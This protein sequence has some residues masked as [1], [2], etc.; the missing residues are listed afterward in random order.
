MARV[1]RWRSYLPALITNKS[2]SLFGPIVPR[3]AE[4]NRMIFCGRAAATTRATM[5]F[6]TRGATIRRRP[7]R[8]VLVADG[9]R[10]E[11]VGLF[12][13]GSL[14][15]LIRVSILYTLG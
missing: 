1:T 12:I 5:S 15:T 3:A 4:P 13:A 9:R 10:V 11:A 6:S 2:R 14:P 8:T 7:R